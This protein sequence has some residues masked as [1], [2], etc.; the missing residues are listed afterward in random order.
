MAI[1]RQYQNR[2]KQNKKKD[3]MYLTE[4]QY[5]L[6]SKYRDILLDIAAG[7]NVHISDE[8]VTK[9]ADIYDTI[10]VGYEKACRTG[11]GGNRFLNTLADAYKRYDEQ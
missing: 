9:L 6:L 11:C 4:E 8:T 1:S 3:K 7:Y 2:I 5:K 10:A